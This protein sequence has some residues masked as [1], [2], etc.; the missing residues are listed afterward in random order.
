MER[1]QKGEKLRKRTDRD[2]GR[3]RGEDRRR[4]RE[5][6]ERGDRGGDERGEQKRET[7]EV[8]GCFREQT[9][10]CSVTNSNSIFTCNCGNDTVGGPSFFVTD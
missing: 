1:S 10:A 3:R 2:R 5:E 4:G 7:E 8:M 9:V 6:G